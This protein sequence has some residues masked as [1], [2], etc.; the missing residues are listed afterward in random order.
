MTDF[1]WLSGAPPDTAGYALHCDTCLVA[2]RR[3]DGTC[4]W[5]CGRAGQ[6]GELRD[7]CGTQ[8]NWRPPAT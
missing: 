6:P 5:L 3:K 7:N 8:P 4:C 2:W 1:I